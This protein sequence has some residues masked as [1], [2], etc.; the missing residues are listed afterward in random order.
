MK[1]TFSCVCHLCSAKTS[2]L[3]MNREPLNLLVRS[4]VPFK[5]EPSYISLLGF[6]CVSVE[7]YIIANLIKKNS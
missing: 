4:L 1:C 5:N 7:C 3:T 6:M 2:P